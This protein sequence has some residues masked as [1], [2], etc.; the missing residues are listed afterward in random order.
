M[1]VSLLSLVVWAVLLV[2][3]WAWKGGLIRV[4]IPLGGAEGFPLPLLYWLSVAGYA[5]AYGMLFHLPHRERWSWAIR[6][7]FGL[8]LFVLIASLAWYLEE[9][10]EVALFRWY[11]FYW[12]V[13]WAAAIAFGLAGFSWVLAQWRCARTADPWL[14]FLP[15]GGGYLTLWISA[16]TMP[17]P[18]TLAATAGGL[19]LLETFRMRRLQVWSGWLRDRFENERVFLSCVVLLALALR[20]FYTS[21][22]MANPD[23]LNTG[24]DGPIYDALAWALAQGQPTPVESVPSWAAQFFSPGYVRFVALIY[25]LAGR[26]YLAVCAVQSVL[27]AASCLLIYAIAKRLF[28]WPVARLSAAFGAVNFSMVFAATAMGHQALD[29][30]WTLAVVWCLLRYLNDPVRW[31]RWIVGIG[32][33]LGWAALIREGHIAFWMFLIGWFLLG[34]RAKL[35]WSLA[36]LHAS[37]LSLGFLVVQLLYASGGVGGLVDRVGSLWFYYQHTDTPINTWFNPWQSPGAAWALFQGQPLTVIVKVGEAMAGNFTAMFL[38]Q[39]YGSF[40]PVFLVRGS[41][42]FEGMWFYALFLALVGLGVVCLEACRKPREH[43]GW[44]LIIALLV[45]R[46]AVHLVLASAYRYRAPL[47][48]YLIMLAAVGAAQLL[49]AT[50]ATWTGKRRLQHAA[51][52]A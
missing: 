11:L 39:G 43:L 45:S 25:W 38:H 41:A 48:P 42:Y 4:P 16:S 19:V 47:E 44:W 14:F 9:N 37:G 21:R 15:L 35:G 20:L 18:L 34:M 22:V 40:D 36:L 28:G 5:W 3:Q 6:L 29:V 33:L 31:G 30:V 32:V 1:L 13:V 52:P 50:D 12:N 10:P 24:S 49:D 17:I 51:S 27:G 2:E 46:T 23:F 8:H 26:S 7:G